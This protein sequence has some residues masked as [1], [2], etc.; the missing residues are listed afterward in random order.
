MTSLQVA[1]PYQ[2]VIYHHFHQ[3]MKPKF[4][5]CL[6]TCHA[7]LTNSNAVQ[8]IAIVLKY[9]SHFSTS[10]IDTDIGINLIVLELR[11]I[12]RTM[13]LPISVVAWLPAP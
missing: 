6:H 5:L 10:G 1:V 9:F 11:K 4:R 3:D 13:S 7:D 12:Y 2:L 8:G